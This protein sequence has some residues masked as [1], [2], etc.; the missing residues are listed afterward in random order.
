MSEQK[1]EVGAR[2]VLDDHASEAAEKLKEGFEHISERVHEAQHEMAGFAKQALAT[3][4]G[5]Q[6][7]RGL[8]SIKEFGEEIFKAARG[9]AQQVKEL[10]G[11]L[12]ITDKTGASLDEL[13]V[14]AGELHEELENLGV[15][16]GAGSE[17]MVAAFGQ[18]AERS[19]KS[20][21]RVKEMV[22]Q[23]ALAGKAVPGGLARIAQGYR[24]LESGIVRPRNEIVL[25]MKQTGVAGG[26]VKEI[27]KGMSHLMQ[28]NPAKAFELA[29]RAIEIMS[30]KMKDVPLSF[31]AVVGSLKDIREQ[32]FETMGG[33]M[34]KALLTPLTE[35]RK[36][37]IDNKEKFG[38]YAKELGEKVGEWVKEAAHMV[39]RGFEWV[40]TH[41]DEISD[42]I[43]QGAALLKSAV[44]FLLAHKEEIR[45]LVLAKMGASALD[46]GV[47]AVQGAMGLGRAAAGVMQGGSELFGLE[48]SSA[49]ALASVGAL[50]AGIAG[51]AATVW[52]AETIYK[53]VSKFTDE[54]SQARLDALK[55]AAEAGNVAH[56]TMVEWRDALVTVHPEMVQLIDHL[57]Q[58]G[59]AARKAHEDQAKD[60]HAI[61]EQLK[62]A[63][64]NKVAVQMFH[65]V[66]KRMQAAHNEAQMKY[67]ASVLSANQTL[68]DAMHKAGVDLAD[69]GDELAKAYQGVRPDDASA[70]AEIQAIIDE[71]KKA[72]AKAAVSSS[73]FDFRGSHFQITQDFRDQDPDRLI[74]AF[75]RDLGRVAAAQTQSRLA[76]GHGL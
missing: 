39:E 47:G 29:D 67:L 11:L 30:K 26:S 25:L 18:I 43:K 8:D 33:P 4:V 6:L 44:E 40:R 59:D 66:F 53:D 37:L 48:A 12:A 19:G 9:D 10:Q 41:A 22:E 52:A 61:G 55:R 56:D 64:G 70:G 3:A 31:D 72:A 60:A 71:Q 36:Y 20:T 58:M 24:D 27:A 74:I 16:T 54:D 28:T 7:D 51:L 68:V 5:F 15:A 49:G 17:D 34:V 46:K 23:M 14:K 69:I 32:L 2:L 38:E 63:Q 13:G 21:E 45:D 62:N 57:V 50:A 75:Q 76:R 35:L 1:T 73:V 65:D 42:A